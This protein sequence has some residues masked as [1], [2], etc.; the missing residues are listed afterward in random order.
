MMSMVEVFKTNVHEVATAKMLIQKLLDHFQ[1]DRI[2]F[3]LE[4]CDRVLRV[5][6]KRFFPDEIIDLM[7]SHG[8]HCEVLL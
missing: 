7:T 1:A 5:E 8:Y 2:S 4:D 6:G 3:D